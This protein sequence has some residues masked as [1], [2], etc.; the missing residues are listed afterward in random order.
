MQINSRMGNHRYLC[1]KNIHAYVQGWVWLPILEF[2]CIDGGKHGYKKTAAGTIHSV[3]LFEFGLVWQSPCFIHGYYTL[4][5]PPLPSSVVAF[6]VK[7]SRCIM[8]PLLL[9]GELLRMEQDAVLH[10]PRMSQ[11]MQYCYVT[12]ASFSCHLCCPHATVTEQDQ[13]TGLWWQLPCILLIL[14]WSWL[15]Q[16]VDVHHATVRYGRASTFHIPCRLS[17]VHLVMFSCNLSFYPGL[18]LFV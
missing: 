2:I 16:N 3:A 5:I 12:Y 1:Y 11:D 7:G 4:G 13:H 17:P 9:L 18:L 14:L 8:V 15:L 6:L 10:M